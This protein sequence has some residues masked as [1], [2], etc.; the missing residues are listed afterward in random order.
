[1][2]NGWDDSQK[3]EMNGHSNG[4]NGLNGHSN[5]HS[6]GSSGIN[7]LDSLNSNNSNSMGSDL[8]LRSDNWMKAKKSNMK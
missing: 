8:L 7:R 4:H 5:G 6:N 1:M 3:L 2:L